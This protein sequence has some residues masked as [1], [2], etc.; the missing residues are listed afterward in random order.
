M[1]IPTVVR[2]WK[3]SSLHRGGDGSFRGAMAALGVSGEAMS[4]QAI[5]RGSDGSFSVSS[6]SL[7][8][9]VK[10]NMPSGETV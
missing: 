7:S 1:E 8:A 3:T 5:F 2:F 4:L 9:P 10:Q 6:L